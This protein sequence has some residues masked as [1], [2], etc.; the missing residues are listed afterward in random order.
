MIYKAPKTYIT[1]VLVRD[2]VGFGFAIIYKFLDCLPV[3]LIFVL[4]FTAE[5]FATVLGHFK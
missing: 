2:K 5:Y 1:L 3:V 4:P